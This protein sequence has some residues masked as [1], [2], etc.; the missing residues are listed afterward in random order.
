MRLL[1]AEDDLML[2]EAISAGLRQDGFAVDW[3]T[4][5]A[6]TQ[7]ALLTHR[8]DVLLLDLGLPG[9]SGMGVLQGM[10]IKGNRTP[11]I[12][13][14]ARD[15]PAH[16]IA[17]L[18][19]GADDYMSKPLDLDVL[20]ARVRAVIRRTGGGMSTELAIGP[21]TIDVASRTVSWHGRALSLSAREYAILTTLANNRG[22]ILSRQQ[23]EEA[24]Y[25]WTDEIESNAVEVHVH[26]LRRKTARE[27]I[28]TVRN[29][30]YT[31]D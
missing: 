25:G 15:Q 19:A 20:A 24:L 2:G 31:I 12:V 27:I 6:Q 16:L 8:Y 26:H 28:R 7:S 23:L 18:D 4:D 17:G 21:L 3:I 11:V 30:G 29:I 14:S 10:R 22:R 13:I 5:G 9:I 1:L